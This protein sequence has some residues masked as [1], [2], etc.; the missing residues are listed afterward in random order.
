MSPEELCSA[1]RENI[2]GLFECS[3]TSTDAL[4]VRTPF[5]YPDGDFIDLYV[6][7]RSQSLHLTDYGETLGWLQ[8]QSIAESLT[9]N[10]RRLVED[11]CHTLGIH[12]IHGQL[13]LPDERLETLSESIGRLGQAAV[14][15]SDI[16]FTLRS[17]AIVSVGDEVEEWLRSQEFG[18]ERNTEQLGRSGRNWSIDY[19]VTSRNR[20]SH[21]FLLSSGSQSWARRATE[22][23][24]AAC[25]DL[26]HLA[27]TGTNVGLVSLF[28][29]SMDV[30]REEDFAL[31]AHLSAVTAWSRRTDLAGILTG[32]HSTHS[33]LPPIG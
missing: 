1:I 21:M 15:V 17:R 31:L 27:R 22:R 28:D 10:Q 30:W 8:L 3:Q 19:E 13:T 11:V 29:D 14:R 7:E 23:V 18:V 25:V 20:R 24:A 32:N 6:E 16:W 2:S 4:R 33:P 9:P 5:M 12:L 26:S